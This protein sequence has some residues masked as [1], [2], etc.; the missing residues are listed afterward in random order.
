VS[1]LIDQ[2]SDVSP[3]TIVEDVY[4]A[5]EGWGLGGP[6]SSFG[7]AHPDCSQGGRS[8]VPAGR[9]RTGNGVS[10]APVKLTLADG[11]SHPA[12][13]SLIFGSKKRV[14]GQFYLRPAGS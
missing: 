6:R 1:R 5:V 4:A 2:F 13:L 14:P 11:T 3:A 7:T 9:A 8:A 10:G 12:K